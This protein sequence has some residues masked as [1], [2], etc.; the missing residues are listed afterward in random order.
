MRTPP[1]GTHE[2]QLRDCDLARLYDEY[3]NCALCADPLAGGARD[4]AP[5]RG[6]P[7]RNSSMN[8]RGG[9]FEVAIVSALSRITK[10]REVIHS[11]LLLHHSPATRL[12]ARAYR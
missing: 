2:H 8:S 11:L 5:A 3:K 4:A 6:R 10:V 9:G 1:P 7:E 12:A